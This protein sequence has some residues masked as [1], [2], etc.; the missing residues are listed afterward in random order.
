[1]AVVLGIDPGS[2]V[3][4]YGVIRVAGNR[5]TL[6]DCGAIRCGQG[7]LAERLA[8]I[9]LCL[10]EV[11]AAHAPCQ[12]AIEKVFVHRSAES[13]MRLGHARGVA[14]LALAQAGLQV[15][16]YGAPTVKQA[17]TGTGRADK[18]QVQHMVQT[19]LGV[20]EPLQADAADALAVA[21]CHA[22]SQ[23]VPALTART[24]GRRR[25]GSSRLRQLPER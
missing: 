2:R 11:I 23:Q 17:V 5:Q 10:A 25:R 22:N 6:V 8:R 15:A 18:Q 7:E 1:M 3:T 20:R 16:E 12:A 9:H 19:L 13:A 24:G 4:G 21:I 14:M